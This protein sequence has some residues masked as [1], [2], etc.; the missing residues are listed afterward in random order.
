M[1]SD[2]KILIID[3]NKDIHAD[4][5][6]VFDIA[7]HYAEDLDELE[8][9]LFG[10]SSNHQVA[11]DI[12]LQVSLDFAYQGEE[13]LEKVREAARQGEPFYMAFVDVRMPPGIDG[14][15]TI[16]RLWQEFPDL[17]CVICTAFSDYDWEDIARELG[18]SGNLLILKKPFDA[19]EVLQLAQALAEK[20]D[21]AKS[22]Q[23]YLETLERKV[24]E[25]TET[26]AALQRYNEELLEAK[27]KLEAQTAEL[28]KKSEQ[29]E[30]ARSAAEAASRAKS[31]FLANMSHELRT[32]LNGVMGM[33]HLLLNTDLTRP[34][35]RYA[36]MAASSAEMLLRLINDILDFS[37]IEAGKLELEAIDFDVRFAVETVVELIAPQARKKGLEIACFVHPDIP[38]RLLGDPGRLRQVLANLTSNAVKFTQHGEVVVQAMLLHETEHAVSVRFTVTDT[39]I[40]IPPD[41][42]DRLFQSFSQIDSS[43]TRKYGGTGLGLAISKRLC[44]LMGGQV[45]V[46]SQPGKGSTFWCTLVLEKPP[47]G[48]P[49]HPRVSAELRG[50]RAL[51]VEDN[52]THRQILQQQLATWGFDSQTASDGQS[53][54]AL[55]RAAVAS[56]TPFRLAILDIQMPGM[57]GEELA[58]AIKASPELANT[59]LIALSYLGDPVDAPQL[60][61]RGFAECVT[62]PVQQ[63][64]LLDAMLRALAGPEGTPGGKGRETGRSLL[65]ERRPAT[66]SRRKR[67]RILLAEDNEI[68]Q[69]L[70]AA[71]LTKAGYPCDIVPDG[72]QVVERLLRKRYDLILMDCHMPEMDGFEATRLIRESEKAGM[73]LGKTPGPL[74]ILALTAN[75]MPGDRERCLEA[76]MTDYLSKPFN[77]ERVIQM[78]DSYLASAK[79][80][81]R[82]APVSPTTFVPKLQFGHEGEFGN[83]EGGVV[84]GSPSR[85]AAPAAVPEERPPALVT[86]SSPSPFDFDLLLQRCM[87][88]RELLERIIA[89]FRERSAAD[90]DRLERSIAAGDAAQVERLAH[91]FKGVAANLSAGMLRE[92]AAGMEALGRTADL[93]GASAV[94]AE[95]RREL[96]RFFD[97]VAA[98]NGNRQSVLG[99]NIADKESPELCRF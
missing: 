8:A 21:L 38:A 85:G 28:A 37:K 95:L 7:H 4:F 27:E 17:P 39:G 44:E 48:S 14:I 94:L 47:G 75:A 54:L 73:L 40:G 80:Q 99:Q 18:R 30:M 56:G 90:L 67:S 69:S 57:S 89:K 78:I 77:P 11:N 32:P 33:T 93:G 66:R 87:G 83:E 81:T 35:R 91:G 19:I 51:V 88:D 74:P 42:V 63:S 70:I 13:G 84:P 98:G 86:H 76:G 52:A 31:D 3:D 20:V 16:K 5:R 82:I 92:L 23:N 12:L 68:N 50:T 62:K 2:R 58:Q 22:V 65:L 15:Q 97:C 71:I 24:R 10:S 25:L 41:R 53:A 61:S 9:D 34:Q 6:K 46:E 45:G 79:I 64:Q 55:L 1:R 96:Q 29:L 49:E 72:K 59:L 36:R 43:T 26:E 60:R